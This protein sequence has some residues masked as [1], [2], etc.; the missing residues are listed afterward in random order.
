MS[1]NALASLT[2]TLV[3]PT[4]GTFIAGAIIPGEATRLVIDLSFVEGATDEFRRN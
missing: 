2:A 1:G 3:V 4:L